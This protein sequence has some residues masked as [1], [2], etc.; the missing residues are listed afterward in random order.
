M[1]K[2]VTVIICAG[3]SL[4]LSL[5]LNVEATNNKPVTAAAHPN[6]VSTCT[7]APCLLEDIIN[8]ARFSTDACGIDNSEL[9]AVKAELKELKSE[10]RKL[11]KDS[12]EYEEVISRI[13]AL[14]GRISVLMGE[15]NSKITPEM[16]GMEQV[17]TESGAATFTDYEIYDLMYYPVEE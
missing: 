3:V 15:I 1:K 17:S 12:I 2:I 4:G 11:R 5:G 6:V 9:I 13:H 8:E 7:I 10:L 14:W 16:Y